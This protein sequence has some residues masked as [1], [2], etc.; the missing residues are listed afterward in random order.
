MTPMNCCRLTNRS[1]HGVCPRSHDGGSRWSDEV[2]V[3]PAPKIGGYVAVQTWRNHNHSHN[4][5]PELADGT[6]HAEEAEEEEED[7]VVGVIFEN[8]TCGIS[9]ARVAFPPRGNPAAAGPAGLLTGSSAG[10]LHVG[11]PTFRRPRRFAATQAFDLNASSATVESCGAV[12]DGVT[13]ASQAVQQCIHQT[14]AGGRLSFPAGQWLVSQTIMVKSGGS[15]FDLG[16]TGWSS[17]VLW[18]A[19]EHLFQWV[20]MAHQ[21]TLHDLAITSVGQNKSPG[22]TAIRF[23]E[24]LRDS[25]IFKVLVM[26]TG[27]GPLAG[28][29]H[30]TTAAGGGFDLGVE[31]LTVELTYCEVWTATG[32]GVKVGW[33][34][35]VRIGGGRFEGASTSTGI[36]VLL[37]GGNGGVHL[38]TTDVGLWHIG[39]LSN[40]SDPAQHSNV[41]PGGSNRELFLTQATLDSCHVG[42]LILDQAYV[43][44]SGLWVASSDYANIHVAAP[45]CRDRSCGAP[46]AQQTKNSATLVITG[47]TLFNAAAAC[48]LPG[49]AARP[50]S[51]PGYGILLE[52]GMLTMT[53][54]DIRYNKGAAVVI[55]SNASFVTL[56]GNQIHHN[57]QAIH[58]ELA[59]DDVA[60]VPA[61]HPQGYTITGN[62]V[63]SNI[64]ASV[65]ASMPAG[66]QSLSLMCNNVGLPRI[67]CDEG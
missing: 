64:N 41:R 3:W 24:G 9:F 49:N 20:G 15:S 38:T 10:Q 12:G 59:G 63:F 34:A 39:L 13:D 21:V 6:R 35:E 32:F 37:T 8:D 51:C 1:T 14:Q 30:K 47:G 43:S 11:L 17:N 58:L 65:V 27:G 66:S 7:G 4:H 56:T 54:V 61:G 42:M 45:G 44:V 50:A 62:S 48:P 28:G 31:T 40:Q 18:A 5:S 19:D 36:G 22:S 26:G 16:G 33:G 52:V 57:G 25:V 2:M 53:G 23:T 29:L 67:G 55:G 60:A 46:S